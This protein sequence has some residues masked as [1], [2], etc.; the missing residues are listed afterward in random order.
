MD[1]TSRAR[2]EL[3][4]RGVDFSEEQFFRQVRSGNKG[5]VK[6]LLLAGVSPNAALDGETALAVAAKAGHKD[7]AQVLLKAGADPV[8]LVDGIATKGKSKD[9]WE[10]LAS[11]SG[12]FTFISS[13]LIASVG[14]YFTNAYNNRQ[15]E[16]TQA[17]T[18]RDQENKE[19]QNR[20]SELQ[21]V[22]K[23]I[24]HLAK[25][26]PSKRAALIA[27]SV[28]ATPKLAARF[29]EVYGGQGS[30][31]ALTQIAVANQ[32]APSAPAVSALTNLAAQEKGGRSGP[33]RDALA[34]VL[35]GKERSIVQLRENNQS[36]C[37][38]FVIDAQRGWIVT[39]G[40]CLWGS[41]ALDRARQLTVQLWDGT[42]ADVREARFTDRNLL[43]FVRIDA[44]PLRQLEVSLNPLRPGDTVTQLA[45]D[46]GLKKESSTQLRV[47]L[48][49]ITEVGPMGFIGARSTQ[50]SGMGL[51]VTLPSEN[52]QGAAGAPLL[53]SEGNVAC[54]TYQGDQNRMEECVAAEEIRDALKV[55]AKT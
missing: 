43:A 18:L 7:I 46:L 40:S 32:K 25:D 44:R 1:A 33:A 34:S 13:L 15:L 10:K 28:L 9:F 55:I 22:E 50:L 4:R 24:P 29:A 17:Q 49:R 6:L 23:M 48:G 36:F 21:T 5:L 27:I 14:W 8:C 45:F 16:L 26:E 19:Y 20:L 54:M 38:G 37:N 41:T 52:A 47:T 30:V 42:L 51:R 11:F 12:V 2:E 31:D 53:D 39:A 3:D 35:Q